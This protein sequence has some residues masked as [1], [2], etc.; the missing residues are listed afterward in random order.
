MKKA[1]PAILTAIANQL[2]IESIESTTAAKSGHPTSCCSAAD[3]VSTL[4]FAQMRFDPAHPRA[5]NNDR[6]V[7]SKGHAAP[8]LYAAWAELGHFPVQDLLNLRKLDS[9]LEGHPTPLLDFVDVAT[10]S[11]GQGLS[12]GLGM[13][14]K[15]KMDGLDFV[16]YVL[17]GDGEIS[18]GSVWEAAS[19]A[20]VRKMTNLVAI[21]DVNR[22]GQSQ[23][24]AFGTQYAVYQKR[25]QAF[26]WEAVIVDGHNPAQI[27]KAL[28]KAG[29]TKL[30]LAI[31]AKTIKGKGISFAENKDGWHGKALSPEEAT[32]AIAQLK[33]KAK[34]AIG[35]LSPPMPKAKKKT[36]AAKKTAAP[37]STQIPQIGLTEAE[38]NAIE[39]KQAL[40]SYPSD[41]P[42]SPR[43]AFGNALG[44]LGDSIP[45]LVVLDGDVENS[46]FTNVFAK[47]FPKRFV[48]SYISEQN[49]MGMAQGLAALGKIPCASTFAAFLSRAIDQIRMAAISSLN[50]KIVGTHTGVSIGEDGGSQMGL[51]DVSQFRALQGSI[52]FSP[53]D[54]ISTER[55]TEL[56]LKK[57]GIG[58]LRASRGD[59]PILY[60]SEDTFEIGGAKVLRQTD[61]DAVT[62]VASGVTVFEA[63]KAAEELA[64]ENLNITV[65]DAYCIKPLAKDLILQAASKTQFQILTVEDHAPEGG[66]GDAVAGDLSQAGARVTKLAVFELPHSGKKDELLAKYKINSTAII[67][68]V[69]ELAKNQSKKIA[70]A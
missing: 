33:K 10:G 49:M 19:L 1:T 67:E 17:M 13:A 59:S 31:I 61:R 64:K 52:V 62:V 44:R 41:K 50:I 38:K 28:Q 21:V 25:F 39:Q 46:T 58:Y 32:K 68:T 26:G 29:K 69:R 30:P 16:T 3:L 54:A 5:E 14:I 18:E 2:R 8:L 9:P 22:L 70:A 34:S 23:Q 4:F 37:S 65:I 47:N 57:Q 42:V 66:L 60:K 48:E 11:L 43:Q 15:A 40:L 56:M 27:M 24:T 6:F 51:E 55:V 45:E 63:L 36:L 35:L 7:L 20:G 12:A 53:C